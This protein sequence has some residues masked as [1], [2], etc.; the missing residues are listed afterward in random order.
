MSINKLH[1][2]KQ[3]FKII[4]LNF[5]IINVAISRQYVWKYAMSSIPFKL[6][7]DRNGLRHRGKRPAESSFQPPGDEIKSWIK[8]LGM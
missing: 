1:L 7:R 3:S 8:Y 2:I 6:W 4:Q 5:A